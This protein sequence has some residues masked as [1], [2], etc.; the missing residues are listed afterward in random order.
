MYVVKLDWALAEGSG[1]IISV[2]H[3]VPFPTELFDLL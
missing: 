1:L 3:I 2:F